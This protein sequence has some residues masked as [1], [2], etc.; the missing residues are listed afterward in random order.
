M[1]YLKGITFAVL[2]FF[3]CAAFVPA[4]SAERDSLKVIILTENIAYKVGENIT[5]EVRVYDAT[6]L[7]EADE[8]EVKVQ[9]RWHGDNK[10]I[11]IEEISPG[12]YRGEYQI[13]EEDHYLSFSAWARSGPDD[14]DAGL[15]AEIYEGRLDLDVHFSHQSQAYLW[16]GQSAKATITAKYRDEPVDVDGFRYVRLVDSEEDE[17]DLEYERV[18]QGVYETQVV[19]DEMIFE[20]MEYRLEAY[21]EYANAH[22]QS[23]A[24]V[25]VNVLTVWYRL[26]EIVGN[27]ATFTLG[28]ADSNGKSVPNAEVIITY[29]QLER[30][31]TDQD[32]LTLF[33]L[34][35][36]HSGVSVSGYVEAGELTQAFQGEIYMDNPE[37]QEVPAHNRFDVLYQGDDFMYSG[38]SKISRSYKAYNYSI[39]HSNSEIIY[40]ITLEETDF[41][42][43]D[44]FIPHEYGDYTA[45]SRVVK[46][47]TVSTSLLGDFKISFTAPKEQGIIAIHFESGIVR[48]DYNYDPPYETDYDH[49]DDLVYEEDWD[50][51]FIS[52]GNLW[53]SSSVKISSDPLKVG[54]K[55]TVRVTMDKA[56]EDGDELFA[57]W[58]AGAPSNSLYNEE[59]DSEWVSWVDGGNSIFLKETDN[60]KEYKGSSI[61][62]EFMDDNGDFTLVAGEMDGET[63][64]PYANHATLK[65][66]E[67]AGESNMDLLVLIL[68]GGAVLV[69]LIIL[70]FGAFTEKE[71]NKENSQYQQP[72]A[73]GEGSGSPP[74]DHSYDTAPAPLNP[75]LAALSNAADMPPPEA[76][77]G[78]VQPEK[79]ISKSEDAREGAD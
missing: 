68:L 56:P 18:A 46:T 8:I 72:G 52:K 23:Y 61:I 65:E 70:G 77:G 11:E 5:V 44:E 40:Y 35:G 73:P 33:S 32:G 37:E 64:V 76:E 19:M 26:E 22:A 42:L 67:S 7:V 9:T 71:R 34:A 36:I 78:P 62:P 43:N 51:L 6:E 4:A 16:P 30:K 60:P 75:E 12:I 57:M 41:I 54:G 10:H 38:G 48:N 55:T 39:P 69:I 49:D 15:W 66:G 13:E 24:S 45:T 31:Y 27:T 14:D 63:G 47:G 28:V 17:L 58:M 20:N 53:D 59:E 50:F 29:P 21:G 1:K 3:V 74:S 25:I 79:H 2:L